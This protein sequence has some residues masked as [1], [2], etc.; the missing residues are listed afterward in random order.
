MSR[1]RHRLRLRIRCSCGETA[2][3]TLTDPWTWPTL[4]HAPARHHILLQSPVRTAFLCFLVRGRGGGGGVYRGISIRTAGSSLA[5]PGAEHSHWSDQS[6]QHSTKLEQVFENIGV[7]CE[8]GERGLA[9]KLATSSVSQ[10]LCS[11]MIPWF[12]S[13]AALWNVVLNLSVCLCLTLPDSQPHICLSLSSSADVPASLP[14]IY[15]TT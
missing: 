3:E 13:S 12:S 15:N 8:C 10:K 11:R 5:L 14:G 2:P 9:G 1:K 4:C 7:D 6:A